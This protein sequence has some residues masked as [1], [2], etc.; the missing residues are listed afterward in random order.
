M[1]DRVD[2]YQDNFFPFK[3]TLSRMLHP[4]NVLLKSDSAALPQERSVGKECVDFVGE[5]WA[6]NERYFPAAANSVHPPNV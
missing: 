3:A 6:A 2:T 5:N 4:I 1:A